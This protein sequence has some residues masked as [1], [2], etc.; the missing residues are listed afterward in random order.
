MG[1]TSE[2][3][4]TAVHVLTPDFPTGEFVLAADTTTHTS[5]PASGSADCGVHGQPLHLIY[6][7]T[8]EFSLHPSKAVLL[9]ECSIPPAC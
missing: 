2:E 8:Y 4:E 7:Q 3:E 1:L 9:F 5:L 6:V